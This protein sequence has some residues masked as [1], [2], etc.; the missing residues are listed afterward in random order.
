MT[1]KL[2]QIIAIEKD[3]K[4]RVVSFLT[5]AYHTLQKP[6]LFDGFTKVYEKT[7]EDGEDLPDEK[8]LVNYQV[9]EMLQSIAE[10][11][12]EFFDTVA[13]KDKANCSALADVEVDGEV[14]LERIPSTHLIFLEKQL[15]DLRTVIDNLPTLDPAVSWALDAG[16]GLYKSDEQRTAKKTK[17]QEPIVLYKATTEH[18]AQTQLITKDKT[19]GYWNTVKQS[20]AVTPKRKKLLQKRVQEL[21]KAIKFAREKANETEAP[22]VNVGQSIFDYLLKE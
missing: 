21:I 9:E 10:Q 22:K 17:I 12:T 18:P 20:G 8:K 15:K 2:H 13:R 4:S 3:V 1:A 6:A 19:V 11:C 14:L 16:S 5:E 7:D